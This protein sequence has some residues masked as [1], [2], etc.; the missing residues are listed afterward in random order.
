M[1]FVHIKKFKPNKIADNTKIEL[2]SAFLAPETWSIHL[3]NGSIEWKLS[4]WWLS[5][6]M[7]CRLLPTRKPDKTDLVPHIKGEPRIAVQVAEAIWSS[8]LEQKFC[9]KFGLQNCGGK[10]LTVS[11]RGSASAAPQPNK[12][13]ELFCAIGIVP[14]VRGWKFIVPSTKSSRIWK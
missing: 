4:S 9:W 2:F 6:L 13:H 11:L 14:R 8:N 12:E 10:T 3:W 5:W 1:N 7:H